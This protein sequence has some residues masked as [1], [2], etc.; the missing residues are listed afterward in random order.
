MNTDNNSW[1][2]PNKIWRL[3]KT[4]VQIRII[5]QESKADK[6]YN[7]GVSDLRKIQLMKLGWQ[8]EILI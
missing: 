2:M 8:R 7:L 1:K 4:V 5:R 6:K 3:C